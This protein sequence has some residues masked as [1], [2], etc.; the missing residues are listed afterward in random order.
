[1][2]ASKRA[3]E[4]KPNR[5]ASLKESGDLLLCAMLLSFAL[6]ERQGHRFEMAETGDSLRG[7]RSKKIAA[8][9]LNSPLRVFKAKV[10]AV[11]QAPFSHGKLR[12]HEA[13]IR[14]FIVQSKHMPH[15]VHDCG[16]QVHVPGRR[17]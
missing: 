1:M 3:A 7:T 2:I 8:I 10:R 11:R 14:R 4:I 16:Q 15:F 17:R 6:C 9:E 12:V 13:A 5:K